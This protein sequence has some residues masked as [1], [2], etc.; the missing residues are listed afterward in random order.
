MDD[1]IGRVESS[2]A[3][4]L[5]AVPAPSTAHT[6]VSA[7]SAR[8]W[9]SP[10]RKPPPP[11][12]RH[13]PSSNFAAEP[14][15]GRPLWTHPPAALVLPGS[16][17]ILI[18]TSPTSW[19]EC[20]RSAINPGNEAPAGRRPRSSW[21]T[22]RFTSASSTCTT[23]SSLVPNGVAS[24]ADAT[25]V[26]DWRTSTLASPAPMVFCNAPKTGLLVVSVG[27]D[28]ADRPQT[29]NSGWMAGWPSSGFRIVNRIRRCADSKS[30]NGSHFFMVPQKL[31]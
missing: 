20:E 25:V 21:V 3:G 26:P 22:P 17:A 19:P 7:G 27:A 24:D 29:F 8:T 6:V 9:T 10:R 13:S 28:I 11:P 2:M 1:T 14:T 23:S 4:Y 31:S 16:T 18:C 12:P 5:D 15:A 30:A